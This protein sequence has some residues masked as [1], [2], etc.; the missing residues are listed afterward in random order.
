MKGYN[1][2]EYSSGDGYHVGRSE[3]KLDP[4][5]YN[6]DL[7]GYQSITN[8]SSDSTTDEVRGGY[9]LSRCFVFLFPSSFFFFLLY[10]F[11]VS[12]H[13]SPCLNNTP[14][15]SLQEGTELD[16]FFCAANDFFQEE[17]SE[18]NLFEHLNSLQKEEMVR[19]VSHEVGA[20]TVL[21]ILSNS[22]R[23]DVKSA[24]GKAKQVVEKQDPEQREYRKF[25]EMRDWQRRIDPYTSTDDIK[26]IHL[27]HNISKGTSFMHRL[28]FL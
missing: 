21:K 25:L 27:Y 20:E 4:S 19:L 3:K 1:D 18:G 9:R 10:V 14:Q 22:G 23:F 17:E 6:P 24:V 12:Y 16:L 8:N 15:A 26:K 2:G 13:S 11:L 28:F 7:D 5:L